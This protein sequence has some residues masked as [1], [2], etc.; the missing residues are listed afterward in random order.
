MTTSI[1]VPSTRALQKTFTGH[2]PY[3]MND[4]DDRLRPT[5]KHR[6]MILPAHQL[7]DLQRE[8]NKLTAILTPCSKN[9]PRK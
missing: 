4:E 6:T 2:S 5:I 9:T 8:A 7:A 3:A 1:P